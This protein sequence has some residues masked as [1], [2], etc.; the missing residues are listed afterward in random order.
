MSKHAPTV[1]RQFL[2]AIGRFRL[3]G[4]LRELV[5][6]YQG[7]LSSFSDPTADCLEKAKHIARMRLKSAAIFDLYS[8]TARHPLDEQF[9]WVPVQIFVEGSGAHGYAYDGD[10]FLNREIVP[11]IPP[12]EFTKAYRWAILEAAKGIHSADDVRLLGAQL[13]AYLAEVIG[14]RNPSNIRK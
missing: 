9:H 7:I 6:Y 10:V 11:P 14:E 12:N 5:G 13:D 1:I 8:E 2:D 4:P 3:P